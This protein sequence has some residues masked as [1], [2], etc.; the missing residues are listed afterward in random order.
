MVDT[1]GPARAIAFLNEAETDDLRGEITLDQWAERY[2][3]SLTG[4]TDGTR[5]TYTRIYRRAWHDALGHLRLRLVDR[6]R[7][8]AQVNVLSATRSDKTVRNMHG[9][10]SAMLQAAVA[11]GH[12]DANPCKG[13][14][15]PRRTAHTKVP[16]RFLTPEEFHRLLVEVPRHYQPLVMLLAASGIRWSEAEALQ[17]GDV[18]LSAI[19][20]TVR[21]SKSIKWDTSLSVRLVGPT[22]TRRSDRT[23]TLPAPAVDALR[24]LVAGRSS[25]ARLFLGPEGGPLRH[26][27]FYRSWRRAC[28]RAGLEPH[29][30]IHDLRHSHCAWLIAAGVSLPTIQAR[31]GHESV[32]TTIDTYGGLLPSLETAATEAVTVALTSYETTD[33]ASPI[34]LVG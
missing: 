28:Q 11:D 33:K 25:T 13:M 14:R 7:N 5:D 6:E 9:L 31:L 15:L 27:L 8:A 30:R 17:V 2:I 32:T 4:I 12:L 16:K 29:P 20:P 18:E 10:I 23:V 19:S 3:T 22:K 21:V 34:R 26:H 24:P 1:V